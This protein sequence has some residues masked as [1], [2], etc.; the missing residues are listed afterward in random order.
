MIH[1]IEDAKTQASACG[2]VI[3]DSTLTTLTNMI[4]GFRSE[5][6]DL[7]DGTTEHQIFANN[8]SVII[9]TEGDEASVENCLFYEGEQDNPWLETGE[10]SAVQ[11]TL[12]VL[13]AF[14]ALGE[15]WSPDEISDEVVG[16]LYKK[17]E[18]VQA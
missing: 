8:H 11:A 18:E 12:I 13:F 2:T 15:S 4:D 5:P 7:E 10:M 9:Y 1:G 16:Y 14:T 6:T 17:D 3:D